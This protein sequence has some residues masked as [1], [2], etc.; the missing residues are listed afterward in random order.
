MKNKILLYNFF[1]VYITISTVFI[2][3]F[4]YK[5]FFITAALIYFMHLI[6]VKENIISPMVIF[7]IFAFGYINSFFYECD[8]DVAYVLFGITINFFLIH[9]VLKYHI[10]LDKIFKIVGLF[11]VAYTGFS[12]LILEEMIPFISA[13]EFQYFFEKVS[14]GFYGSKL[15]LYYFQ[16][17]GSVFLYIPFVL[18]LLSYIEKKKF[19]TLFCLLITTIAIA[20]SGLRGL[21]L[22]TLF[23][24]VYLMFFKSGITIKAF[25]ILTIMP[26]VIGSI[27]YLN[28]VTDFFNPYESS[29]AVKLGHIESYF[30]IVT[31]YNFIFG[32][33][34]GA[35]Y[36]SKG[37]MNNVSLTEITALDSIRYFGIILTI[38]LFYKIL[39]P[40]E[41]NKKNKIFFVIILVYIINSLTNPML[42]NTYG[43]FIVVWYWY[44][45]FEAKKEKEL[46]VQ[47]GVH[48][49]L[50]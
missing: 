23:I 24:F 8:P 36:Y 25:M 4:A 45:M 40:C 13:E 31:I 50:N 48:A 9:P 34:L 42:F 35:T 41:I 3:S 2:G 17:N 43:P 11:I 16:F 30:D 12:Y 26:V 49:T 32:A 38:V 19:S 46:K 1:I 10:D 20:F 47:S 5:V 18:F 21:T 15:G 28:T 29:N 39:F 27:Y 14:F 7:L 22:S 33:G 6:N 37:I 44:K